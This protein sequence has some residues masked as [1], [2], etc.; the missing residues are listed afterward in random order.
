MTLQNP[1]KDFK[2]VSKD[3]KELQGKHEENID[4]SSEISIQSYDVFESLKL[5]TIKL[6]HKSE[7]I[8]KDL[9]Y[10]KTFRS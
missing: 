1:R 9:V 5:K 10:W 2:S 7:E 6:H 8:C 3:Y 4:N